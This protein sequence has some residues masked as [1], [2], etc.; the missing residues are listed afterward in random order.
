MDSVKNLKSA[1][2][3]LKKFRADSENHHSPPIKEQQR[4]E[5]VRQTDWNLV[6]NCI[7]QLESA[8]KHT[9]S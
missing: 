4:I 3:A 5:I 8:L 9:I 2:K 7:A 6:A 1:I